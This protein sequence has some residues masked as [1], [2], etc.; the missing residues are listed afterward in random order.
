MSSFVL[1]PFALCLSLQKLI[2]KALGAHALLK[3]DA[4]SV[5]IGVT[6]PNRALMWAQGNYSHFS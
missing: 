6:F 2:K 5:E 3:G 4:N 1:Y